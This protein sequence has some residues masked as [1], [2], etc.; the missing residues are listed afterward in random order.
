M[1]EKNTES[2][3][4]S[5][6]CYES[7]EGWAR[8]KMQD[9]L[10]DILEQEVTELLGR[11]KSERRADQ[12]RIDFPQG[13]R[14]GHG[15]ARKL[16]MMNGTVTV[17]RPRVRDLEERFESR[18]LPLFKRQ[19]KEV[20]SLLPELYLHGL[21]T[22]DFELAMRGLLGEGAPLSASSI[23]RLKAKWELEFDAWKKQDLSSLETVYFWADG[24]YVKAGIE[25]R[26][27]A[28]LV[29]IAALSNGDKQVVVCESGERESKESW[30]K[31][32]RDLKARGLKLPK[33]SVADGALGLWSALGEIHP[34]GDEQRCWNHKITNVL[35]DLPKKEQ[36]KASELLKEMPYAATQELCEKK[37]DE[38]VSRYK[39]TDPKAVA[40]L[41][42]DW[43]RM[44]S[45]YSFP[46]AHWVHL[47]TSNVVESPFSAIRLRTD[48]SRRYKRVEGAK[49]M[50][51][52]LLC[53]A[54]KGWR[55]LNAPELLSLVAAGVKFKDGIEV[56][57]KLSKREEYQPETIA[58]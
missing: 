58:A 50:I 35:D 23:Q 49:A 13:N 26:K 47:R 53:V 1:R 30:L 44:I 2:Q 14:N 28:L 31:I 45:F 55:K 27:S 52:K 42:R 22:G 6:V 41:I 24:I 21:S 33:L 36:P 7:L 15:K 37:R 10:Q 18:I 25:D 20:R 39:K 5:R 40:T 11:Q 9:W 38:F 54:E 19:S 56:K 51:W 48:A 17:R 8:G 29:I 43:D 4:E 57:T 16:G 46:E 34:T 3:S 32:L 12:G